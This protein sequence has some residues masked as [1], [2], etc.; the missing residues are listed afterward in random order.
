MGLDALDSPLPFSTTSGTICSSASSR[1]VA[2]GLAGTTKREVPP[3]LAPGGMAATLGLE[4]RDLGTFRGVGG[5]VRGG[6]VPLPLARDSPI[7]F[8]SSRT[9]TPC[10]SCGRS[11]RTTKLQQP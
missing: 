5:G 10:S 9:D 1:L 8:T 7:A 2:G 6:V 4:E 3:L 11:P